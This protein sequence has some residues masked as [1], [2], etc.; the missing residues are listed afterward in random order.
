MMRQEVTL[1]PLLPEE[2][3]ASLVEGIQSGGEFFNLSPGWG[4]PSGL[5]IHLQVKV[6]IVGDSI[7]G[8][9][10]LDSHVSEEPLKG[11]RVE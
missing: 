4:S 9:V 6:I 7:G 1:A 3:G 8:K 10:H 11:S 5:D 2:M